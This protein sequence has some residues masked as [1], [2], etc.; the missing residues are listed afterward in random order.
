MYICVWPERRKDGER[1]RE[2]EREREREGEKEKRDRKGN[3]INRFI[4]KKTHTHAHAQTNRGYVLGENT[5]RDKSDIKKGRKKERN[6]D[7]V[8]GRK[9]GVGRGR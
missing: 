3:K 6:G 4:K 7:G 2:R 9:Q 5:I 8:S 1:K